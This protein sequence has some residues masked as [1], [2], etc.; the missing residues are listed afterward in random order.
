MNIGVFA[1]F[2]SG[3]S[4]SKFTQRVKR[5]SICDDIQLP[6]DNVEP[7]IKESTCNLLGDF[8]CCKFFSCSVLHNFSITNFRRLFSCRQPSIKQLLYYGVYYGATMGSLDAI[9]L[10]QTMVFPGL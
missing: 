6:E 5:N 7:N 10:D 2:Y 1:Y 4:E 3:N 8:D 9:S